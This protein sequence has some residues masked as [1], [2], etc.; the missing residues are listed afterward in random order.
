LHLVIL[1]DPTLLPRLRGVSP[2]HARA[3]I[4]GVWQTHSLVYRAEGPP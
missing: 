4:E 2:D 1:Q 3:R